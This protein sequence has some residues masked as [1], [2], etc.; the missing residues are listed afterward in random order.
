MQIRYQELIAR[1]DNVQIRVRKTW[2]LNLE[3]REEILFILSFSNCTYKQSIGNL[4]HLLVATSIHHL[5]PLL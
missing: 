5:E 2:K 4:A 1:V 3:V